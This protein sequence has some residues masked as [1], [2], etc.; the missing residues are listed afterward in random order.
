MFDHSPTSDVFLLCIEIRSCN[1]FSYDERIRQCLFVD[2]HPVSFFSSW[3]WHHWTI[4]ITIMTFGNVWSL[5]NIRCLF[6]F[7]EIRSLNI[8]SNDEHIRQCFDQWLTF[9]ASIFFMEIR[10]FNNFSY[11]HNIRHCFIIDQHPMSFSSS[12]RWDHWTSCLKMNRFAN[13]SPLTNTR[14]R[15][16]LDRDEI[17]EQFVLSS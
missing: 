10:S 6:L 1:N 11:Q 7:I 17:I 3:R 9:D 15:F 13:V 14:C 2:Q 12:S 4:S 5:N 8:F 16:C